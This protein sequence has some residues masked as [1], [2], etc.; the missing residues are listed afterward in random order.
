MRRALRYVRWALLLPVIA[1]VFAVTVLALIPDDVTQGALRRLIEGHTRASFS[2]VSFKKTLLPGIEMEGVTVTGRAKEPMFYFD[3]L[4]VSPDIAPIVYGGLGLSVDGVVKGGGVVRLRAMTSMIRRGYASA[5][6]V[7]NDLGLADVPALSEAGLKGS[8][9][10]AASAAI[11]IRPG[12]CPAGTLRASFTD[13]DLSGIAIPVAALLFAGS[14][15]AEV[16]FEAL[17]TFQARQG[18]C[19]AVLKGLWVDGKEFSAKVYGEFYYD[20]DAAIL[21]IKPDWN[22]SVLT[23]ELEPKTEDKRA[24]LAALFPQHRMAA[25]FYSMNLDLKGMRL[26][27]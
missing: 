17:S 20:F 10:A 9:I 18:R 11:A 3:A 16:S 14:V 7:V 15:K 2:A 19:K 23:V 13:V 25:N 8:G 1:A 5:G 4:S 6:L 12:N 24:M 27:Q 26:V 22:E 21:T